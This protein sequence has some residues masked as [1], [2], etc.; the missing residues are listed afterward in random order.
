[1][2][3]F[4]HLLRCNRRHEGALVVVNTLLYFHSLFSKP[5][6]TL[7]NRWKGSYS[8]KFPG[9]PGYIIYTIPFTKKS[10]AT[11]VQKSTEES[12]EQV[13]TEQML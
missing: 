7:E 1:M 10:T 9:S 2:A 13:K 6:R 3:E 5:G 12:S 11:E 4:N 8:C